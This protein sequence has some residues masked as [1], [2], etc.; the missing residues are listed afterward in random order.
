MVFYGNGD[1]VVTSG[2]KSGS[3][4]IDSVGGGNRGG[5]FGVCVDS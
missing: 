4:N 1:N 2:D 5:I 3:G